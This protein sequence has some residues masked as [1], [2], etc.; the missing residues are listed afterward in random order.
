MKLFRVSLRKLHS[1]IKIPKFEAFQSHNAEQQTSADF[2]EEIVLLKWQQKVFSKTERIYYAQKE[3][4]KTD[5]EKQYHQMTKESSDESANESGLIFTYTNDDKFAPL[6]NFGSRDLKITNLRRNVDANETIKDEGNSHLFIS[7]EESFVKTRYALTNGDDFM[8]MF[9]MADLEPT[10]LLVSIFYR[11]SDGVFIIYPDFNTSD[12]EYLLEIDQ[13][14]K[15]SFGYNVENI[16]LG[17]NEATKE[18]AEKEKLAK[19]QEETCELMKK[20][21]IS[22]D[23][24]FVYPK[25]CRVVLLLEII[26]GRNFE[27]ENLHVQFD[28]KLPKFVKVVEGG[29]NGATHSSVGG[30]V[31]NFGFCHCLVLDIDDEFSLSATKVDTITINF[32]VISIDQT[33]KR[34]RREGIAQI[35]LPLLGKTNSEIFD[36]PCYRD[37]QGGSW[38]IDFFERFFLG[39]VHKTDILDQMHDD[40]INFYG[41]KTI[42]TGNIRLKVQKMT[43]TK[44]SKRSYDKMKTVDEIIRSYHKAKDRLQSFL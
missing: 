35:K 13:N 42:S 12:N 3:H 40:S 15:Q 37:L 26:D 36:L 27:Y 20:L 34:E 39:G 22:K 11:A 17:F 24:Q 31:V 9:I 19:I 23:P 43:Q 44:V 32:E 41:N 2:F 16:S 7:N 21:N 33:W 28:M 10:T 29:L 14:S 30:Q 4:C 25:F 8:K 5:L 6:D 1:I 18:Q 38:I